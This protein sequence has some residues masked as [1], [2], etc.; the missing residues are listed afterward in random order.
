MVFNF[1]KKFQFATRVSL[2]SSTTEAIRESK[3]SVVV[4]HNKLD[5][6]SNTYFLSFCQILLNSM[7]LLYSSTIQV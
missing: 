4:I 6:E 1:T 3:L 7:L 2:E 5:W